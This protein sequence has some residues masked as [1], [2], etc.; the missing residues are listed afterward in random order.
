MNDY[1]EYETSISPS[2]LRSLKK[3]DHR[4]YEKVYLHY[5]D[6]VHDFLTQ[7]TRSEED[8]REITQ[9]IF[10]RLWE[11]RAWIKPSKSFEGYLYS[12]ARNAVKNLVAQ[13]EVCKRYTDFLSAR[14]TELEAATDELMMARETD[15]LIS[16]MIGQM[17]HQ[18][19]KVFRLNRE[20]GMSVNDIARTLRISKHTVESHLST[21]KREI[22]E[23]LA[24]DD[25]DDF[26]PANAPGK[27]K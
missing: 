6:A 11:K 10:I 24:F 1:S 22:K 15:S 2:V 3:G 9:E 20:E 14:G 5:A 7:L 16:L 27:W 25:G 21:A 26:L 12:I 18:R 13:R 23:T 17:P 8:A 4:A 19:Q